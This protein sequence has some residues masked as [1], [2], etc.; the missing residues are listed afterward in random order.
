[1]AAF[2]LL[3]RQLA[4]ELDAFGDSANAKA[5]LAQVNQI[6]LP[7]TFGLTEI[8]TLPDNPFRDLVVAHLA[9]ATTTQWTRKITLPAGDFL[10]L[11]VP[12]LVERLTEDPADGRSLSLVHA[13]CL[14]GRDRGAGG[15]DPDGSDRRDAGPAGRAG[16]QIGPV[17]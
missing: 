13:R 12:V 16:V 2:I 10:R 7:F 6:K 14:A 9:T 11:A 5:L 8:Q 15:G 17:R 3:L 1:M 4:I